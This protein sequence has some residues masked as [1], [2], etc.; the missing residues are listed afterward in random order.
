MSAD[1][2]HPTDEAPTPE[3][4]EAQA[5]VEAY[6]T[7]AYPDEPEQEVLNGVEE[8]TVQLE[9]AESRA[10]EYL[11]SL[12]RE[13]AAFQNYKRRVEREREDQRLAI[14][15]GLLLK[16][17]PALDDFNRA[18]DAVPEEQRNDW[19]QGVAMIQRKLERL[20]ADEGVTEMNAP[21]SRL[22]R[23]FTKRSGSILTPTPRAAP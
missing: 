18:M 11:D 9:Q 13:R 4:G 12:Q 2:T 10:A 3:D 19:F 15:G 14:A 5:S 8:L 23:R 7:E 6:E 1:N 20:L 22:T 21:A 17:L 16:L